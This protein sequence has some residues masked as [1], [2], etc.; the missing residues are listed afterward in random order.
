VARVGPRQAALRSDRRPAMNLTPLHLPWLEVAIAVALVG[1]A[2][3]GW[4][5][6]PLRAYRWA[7]AFT[8]AAFAGTVLACLGFYLCR[9][10]DVDAR[11]SFLGDLFGWQFLSIDE[12]NAPLLPVVGLLHFL[13]ALATGRTKMRRFSLTW[14]L[15]YE[16]IRLAMFGC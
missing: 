6:D 4:F 13:T 1:P 5:R 11:A 10:N 8:A 12:L 3:V 16:A 7:L 15:A 9:F 2:C 14:S